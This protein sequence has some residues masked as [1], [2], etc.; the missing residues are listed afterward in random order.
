M[1][2]TEVVARSLPCNKMWLQVMK[3]EQR[4]TTFL[5]LLG[6]RIVGK[7]VINKILT[8]LSVLLEILP[9]TK[10]IA[11]ASSGNTFLSRAIFLR[12]DR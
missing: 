6:Y 10:R 8:L 7:L 12:M 2:L 3:A 9:S 4:N 11:L 1:Q 5:I